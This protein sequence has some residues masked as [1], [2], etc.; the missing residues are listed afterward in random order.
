MAVSAYFDSPSRNDARAVAEINITPLVD[1]MLVLLVIFMVAAPVMT[2]T[3]N[4]NLPVATPPTAEAPPPRVQL[5]VQ[6]D[7]SYM[8]DGQA[9]AAVSLQ[10]ALDTLAGRA[11][12]TVLE[13]AAN[14]DADYQGFATA[15]S[16][17]KESG[18]KNIALQ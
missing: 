5:S 15:V 4:L 3:L 17:A 12:R 18:L 8:L 13:I 14:A 7:G 10:D 9:V 16:A 2:G 1:V 6:V 11:P